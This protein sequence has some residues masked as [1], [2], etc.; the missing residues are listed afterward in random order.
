MSQWH[1]R[2]HFAGVFRPASLKY[3]EGEGAGEGVG[4]D[5]GDAGM[6][7]K[8]GGEE[9]VLCEIFRC[10][11]FLPQSLDLLSAISPAMPP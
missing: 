6:G 5:G 1:A 8:M 7:L 3:G 2:C 10:G 4:A 11:I 9:G